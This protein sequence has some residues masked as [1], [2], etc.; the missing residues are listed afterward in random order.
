MAPKIARLYLVFLSFI[1]GSIL[2][3]LIFH[4]KGNPTFNNNINH[5]KTVVLFGDSLTEQG[6]NPNI[7]GWCSSLNYYWS[8][9]ADIFVRGF[10]G[11][12]SKWGLEMF[13]EVVIPLQPNLVIIFWGA[14]D[15]VSTDVIQHVS[16]YDFENNINEMILRIKNKLPFTSIILITP[17]P[18][19]ELE[20]EK[21]NMEKKKEIIVDR[22]NQRYYFNY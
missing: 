8:R 13:D 16:L 11:Y 21:R 9:R 4:S 2:S 19:W 15:A 14:N 18:V 1:F 22:S 10:G 7:N 17:P 6:N 3:Y 5:R 20:L 12:N